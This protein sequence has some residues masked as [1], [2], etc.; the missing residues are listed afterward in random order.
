MEMD[1]V[2]VQRKN[3]DIDLSDVVTESDDLSDTFRG[4]WL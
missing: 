1:R 4:D 2:V 3:I